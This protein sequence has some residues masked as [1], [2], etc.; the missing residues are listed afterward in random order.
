MKFSTNY[1]DIKSVTQTQPHESRSGKYKYYSTEN[2]LTALYDKGWYVKSATESNSRVADG[3]Q[4]HHVTLRHADHINKTLSVDELVPEL[5]ITNSHNGSSKLL[6]DLQV[7]RC[8][9]DN[10]CVT[11]YA[12]VSKNSI[13]H[14]GN[15]GETILDA[16]YSIVEDTP[17][18]ME[19]IQTFKKLTLSPGERY[20]FGEMALEETMPQIFKDDRY[21]IPE[22][23]KRLLLPERIQDINNDLFSTYNV[24]QEHILKG[25]YFLTENKAIRDSIYF[26]GDEKLGV[27]RANATK[28]RAIK[29]IDRTRN[30]N[31]KLWQ[32]MD[33]FTELVK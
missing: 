28:N 16:V 27:R 7:Y 11:N 5:G 32:L 19:N 17:R 12:S 9:C 15:M 26:H 18:M 8:F 30:V 29:A 33:N 20:T 21:N 23:V 24:V 1:S 10:Q 31:R 6:F 2:I 14:S 3:F 25:A 22:T 4:K 13:R